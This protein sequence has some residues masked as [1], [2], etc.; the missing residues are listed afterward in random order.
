[1]HKNA[2]ELVKSR[3]DKTIARKHHGIMECFT[4]ERNV[5]NQLTDH[6]LGSF[7]KKQNVWDEYQPGGDVRDMIST[8]KLKN[9]GRWVY[10]ESEFPCTSEELDC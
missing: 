7:I 9:G 1:M 5:V 4:V 2:T 10:K 6:R 3:E 8:D